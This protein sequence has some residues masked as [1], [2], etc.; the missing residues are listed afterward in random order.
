MALIQLTDGT[1]PGRLNSATLTVETGEL[2]G[3]IGPNGAGKSTL[4]KMLGGFL[5]T[6]SGDLKINNV[7]LSHLSA[8]KRAKTIAWIPQ[9]TQHS[10]PISVRDAIEIGALNSSAINK[11]I[12]YALNMCNLT[13]LASRNLDQLSGGERARVWIAR[14]LAGKPSVILA[15]EPI[16]ALDIKYQLEVMQL[17]KDFAYK[18]CAVVVLHDL[19]IAARFCDR[20]ILVANQGIIADGRPEAVLTSDLIERAFGVKMH[21]DL[22]STPPVILAK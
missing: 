17:F 7:G 18:N 1:C 21:I 20:I 12:N 22:S 13:S 6:A 11:D 5:D 8:T 3:I 14:A 19:S 2:I 16:A 4:L 10:W 15:D 9:S